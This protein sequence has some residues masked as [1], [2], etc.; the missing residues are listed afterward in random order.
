MS[1]KD[2]RENLIKQLNVLLF[3]QRDWFLFYGASCEQTA[4]VHASLPTPAE[5]GQAL[6][7]EEQLWKKNQHFNEYY[8][9]KLF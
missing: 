6:H 1:K 3:S 5:S 8:E 2:K 9:Y 4:G 7:P